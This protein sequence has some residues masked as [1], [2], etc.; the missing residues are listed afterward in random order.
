MSISSTLSSISAVEQAKLSAITVL[1]RFP[2]AFPRLAALG[3]SR[4]TL[5][6]P[7]SDLC[8]EAPPRSGN[9]FFLVGFNI[10]NPGLSVAHHHHVPAQALNAIKW[11]IPLL[12]ILRNPIDCALA[13]T[14]PTG[15]KFLIG[16]TLGRWLS[17]W[18]TLEPILPAA[19]PVL[20]ESLIADPPSIIARINVAYGTSFS[21]RFPEAGE[22]FASI[23]ASR[24]AI[25]GPEATATPSP[26]VPSE[27]TAQKEAALRPE[28][29]AHSTAEP[30]VE[31]YRR[32]LPVVQRLETQ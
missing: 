23:E 13:K 26:N 30:A 29:E 5:V 21:T 28:A 19:T 22:V 6:T 27:R 9:S 25:V 14:A 32:L 31:L 17:F 11:G 16:T 7:S 8:I 15:K 1:G 4:E 20:F 3:S 10:A 18:R 24:L 2:S 12:T